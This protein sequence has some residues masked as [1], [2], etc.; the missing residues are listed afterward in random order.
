MSSGMTEELVAGGDSAGGDRRQEGAEK[1]RTQRIM[2]SMPTE[3]Q[4]MGAGGSS[5]YQV[6]ARLA[7]FEL[8][9]CFQGL[10]HLI[11]FAC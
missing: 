9:T 10:D 5:T 3:K 4:A 11:D 7:R 1:T 8:P 6:Q 2:E